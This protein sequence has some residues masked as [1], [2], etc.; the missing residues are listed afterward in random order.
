MVGSIG[1]RKSK[2]L[3]V[4]CDGC[5]HKSTVM[6]LGARIVRRPPAAAAAA[7]AAAASPTGIASSI[8]HHRRISQI[9]RSTDPLA[10]QHAH[11]C[12]PMPFW[13]AHWISASRA[14]WT[15]Y[16]RV[17]GQSVQTS[18]RR[19]KDISHTARL[20]CSSLSFL[21]FAMVL[22][23]LALA[24]P[25]AFC[26]VARTLD[27][28]SFFLEHTLRRQIHAHHRNGNLSLPSCLVHGGG[29]AFVQC[30]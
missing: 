21:S 10:Q 13:R 15:L 22:P 3:R 17:C 8:N 5:T 24:S 9:Q 4:V 26:R 19:L 28:A 7:A 6:L 16:G 29:G 20:A 27:M 14:P 11:P 30:T 12:A 1:W 2:R 23:F 18:D 25:L